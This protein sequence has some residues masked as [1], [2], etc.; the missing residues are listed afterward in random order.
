M[1]KILQCIQ[2][3]KLN[4]VR[5]LG[6]DPV[7]PR[8]LIRHC[9]GAGIC[10]ILYGASISDYF[11]MRFFER[12][13]EEKKTLFT[14]DEFADFINHINGVANNSKFY[15]KANMYQVLGKFTKRGHL[16]L[17][18]DDYSTFESFLRS[19]SIVLYKP[20][21]SRG[22]A[23]E[24]WSADTSDIAKLYEKS[25]KKPAI[26]DE[27]VTQHS[28]LAR[29][30]PDS[31]NTVKIFTLMTKDVCH[32]VA[33][34]FRM[35][36]RGTFVD[37]IENG[38]IAANVDMKT[39]K[40][41]GTAYDFKMNQYTHH[42]DTGVKITDFELPNWEDVLRF[43]EE[44]ARAC[45]LAY[46]EWDIGIRENDCVLIEANPNAYNIGTQLGK[47]HLR[48]KQFEELME[49]YDQSKSRSQ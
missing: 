31:V 46:V 35:G 32:F 39:G 48:K 27:L 36:R 18:T 49:L 14:C 4:I 11:E 20:N 37:N 2:K 43:T 13:R 30:N 29:L 38:G 33:A 21:S 7:Q 47:L 24:L 16:L 3:I 10:H 28:D 22:E 6:E 44:C 9:I 17:P 23:I 12:T 19:H 40:I 1:S 15:Y 8:S 25:A 45:P 34:E 41:I 42:P 26:L 5:T